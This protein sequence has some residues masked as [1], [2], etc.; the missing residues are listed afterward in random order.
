LFSAA[1]LF[2]GNEED[3]VS[4]RTI[5]T[6]K[7]RVDAHFMAVHVRVDLLSLEPACEH[8]SVRLEEPVIAFF[9]RVEVFQASVA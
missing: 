8:F 2:L 3:Q 5:F 4:V 7:D 6:A 1:P 9:S